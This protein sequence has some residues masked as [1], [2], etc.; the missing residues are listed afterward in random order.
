[1]LSSRNPQSRVVS[2]T[3]LGPSPGSNSPAIGKLAKGN[4]QGC[5]S[6]DD[7]PALQLERHGCRNDY[8]CVVAGDVDMTWLVEANGIAQ[9]TMLLTLNQHVSVPVLRSRRSAPH[10]RCH[11]VKDRARD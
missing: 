6:L 4:N 8:I 3:A 5:T 7:L 11:A 10:V 9:S 2:L 1:M